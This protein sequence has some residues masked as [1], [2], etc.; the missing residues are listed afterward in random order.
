MALDE[1][2]WTV[3]KRLLIRKVQVRV[4]PGAP[5]M[6]V[7]GFGGRA[8][9]LSWQSLTFDG[10]LESHLCLRRRHLLVNAS[11]GGV[12][13]PRRAARPS[14]FWSLGGASV[15]GSPYYM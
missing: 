7:S 4:L 6:Q 1:T 9:R 2:S 11:L 3:M 15:S 5:N 10:C 14:L 13:R 12:E 8:Y